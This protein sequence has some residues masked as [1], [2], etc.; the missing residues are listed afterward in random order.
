MPNNLIEEISYSD[1]RIIVIRGVEESPCS[2]PNQ[3]IVFELCDLEHPSEKEL[4]EFF[5]ESLTS[6]DMFVITNSH[7]YSSWGA[8]GGYT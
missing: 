7:T 1:T 4:L 2:T 6:N 8:S 3:V 5:D